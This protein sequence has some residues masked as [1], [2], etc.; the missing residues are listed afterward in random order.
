MKKKSLN[1]ADKEW[2]E[3]ESEAYYKIDLDYQNRRMYITDSLGKTQI[4]ELTSREYMQRDR[5]SVV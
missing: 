5:K 2:L 1:V 3:G 4:K